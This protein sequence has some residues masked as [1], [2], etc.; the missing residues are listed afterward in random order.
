VL[1]T[2][3]CDLFG[4]QYPII[5]GGMAHLATAE[6]SSAVSNAGG[7][8]VIAAA[9]YDAEWLRQQIRY[10]KAL[11]DKPF[12]VNIYLPAGNVDAQI[13][14]L[15]AEDVSIVM[16]AAGNPE[17]YL[18]RLKKSNVKVASLI[19]SVDQA[20]RLSQKK[21][22]AIIAEG[23]EAG[24]HIGEVS[25]ISLIPQVVDAIRVPV[26]AAGG[27]AD[28]R[29]L[30][31]AMALGGEGIQMGTRF[32]CSRECIAHPR[33]KQAII[34]ARDTDTLVIGRSI[35]HPVRCLA[36]QYSRDY[37]ELERSGARAGELREIG[38]G[39]LRLGIIEGNIEDGL[40]M[41]GQISGLIQDI[42][43]VKTIIGDIISEAEKTQSE[44]P[45]NFQQEGKR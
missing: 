23:M 20:K 10:T 39:R 30:I 40:L 17:P 28:G 21:V 16:T 45:K 5:Q 26:I 43:P 9:G 7:L 13:D 12:G 14:I 1:K 25:T 18:D 33:F 37:L 31:A 35:G 38:Q 42:K 6:L 15:L 4:I 19:S 22:D 41:A 24:G 2:A 8:G 3:I 44:F 36:N 34:Q 29:A 32:I 11:T 27:I